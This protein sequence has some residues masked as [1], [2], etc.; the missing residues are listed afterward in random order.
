MNVRIDVAAFGGGVP[1]MERKRQADCEQAAT[2]ATATV[3]DTVPRLL[4]R[5]ATC[6]FGDRTL[7]RRE[8][9]S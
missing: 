5:P 6:Y 7:E 3:T 4:G 2:G 8:R 9:M 1:P